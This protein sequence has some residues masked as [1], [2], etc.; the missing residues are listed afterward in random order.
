MVVVSC[1]PLVVGLA[2]FMGVLGSCVGVLLFPV[3]WALILSMALFAWY[4]EDGLGEGCESLGAESVNVVG[5]GVILF[6]FSEA[7]FFLGCLISAFMLVEGG[8]GESWISVE[9]NEVPMWI[10]VVLLSSGVSVSQAH[11]NMLSGNL[12]GALV[13][14]VVTSVLG[15]I[16]VLVQV[17]EWSILPF[18]VSTGL[19]GGVFF[20]ITGFHGLHV[21]VGT[22]LN[23]GVVAVISVGVGSGLM[24]GMKVEGVIW[25]WHFVDVVWLFVLLGLYWYVM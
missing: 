1:I 14:M 20:L 12:G 10:S 17:E 21:V 15:F 9:F 18:S 23:V 6:I 16:F 19:G 8:W 3:W 22:L 13:W 4:V 2:L 7:M 11:N 24:G 5:M 25:Y